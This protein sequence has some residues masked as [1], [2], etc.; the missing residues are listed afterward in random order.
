MNISGILIAV[1]IIAAIGLFIGIFLGVAA[2]I[3]KVEVDEREEKILEVLP[4]N[5]CGGC[6]YA[7]CSGVAAAIVKGE[8]PVNAC[9][10][11]GA[12]VA[13]KVG[14]IMGVEAGSVERKVAF[15]KCNGGCD[16]LRLDYHYTGEEDCRM[17]QFVPNQGPKSCN[18]GCQGYGSCVKV[19]K[20]DAIHVVNGVALVDKEKCKAC[21]QC[22]SVCPRHL[23]E[24]IPYDASFTVACSNKEKGP[25]ALKR[26]DASCIGCGMC[27]KN[28]E[29]GAVVL[30]DFL[31]KID[32]SKCIGCG[33]CAEKCKRGAILKH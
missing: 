17:L 11:G 7:G 31:A 32:Y 12:A 22:V 16:K 10:V 25:V 14:E 3:F 29:A 8:A 23:I 18:F 5:N 26:C 21:G 30:E 27:K 28:C 33:T 19:C 6:G 13:A 20:F 2:N 9:P 4:G 1:A 15:V 24:M